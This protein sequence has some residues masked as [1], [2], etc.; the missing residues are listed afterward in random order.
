M[1]TLRILFE[2]GIPALPMH[3]GLLVAV[4]KKAA[5]RRAMARAAVEIVG[6]SLPI[7][8][9]DLLFQAA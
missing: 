4:S 8:R 1:A 3:E 2:Q 5:A 7:V 6:V 9:K